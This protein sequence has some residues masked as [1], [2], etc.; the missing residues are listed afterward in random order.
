MTQVLLINMPFASAWTPSMGLSALKASLSEN[1]IPSDVRYFNISY[2]NFVPDINVYDKIAEQWFC[3]EWVFGRELFGKEWAQSKRGDTEGIRW[4]LAANME[5]AKLQ[6]LT[7]DLV[8]FRASAGLFL[9]HCVA[10]VDW[11]NYDIVGFT[12]VFSQQVASLAL[13]K[14]IK[15]LWPDKVI[16][17]GG[18]NCEGEM[19]RG[20]LSLF[21]YVDWVFSGDADISFPL[22]VTSWRK[23]KTFEG[24]EGMAYRQWDKLVY[25]GS[26]CVM[27]M[28]ALPF[29]D[30]DDYFTAI[31]EYASDL[32]GAVSVALEFS[33]GCWW[34]A[35]SQCTFCGL[36][37]QSVEYRCK[38]PG[39]ALKEINHAISR[40]GTSHVRLIDNNI[41]PEYFESLL[42]AL[43]QQENKLESLF[44]ET[45]SNLNRRQML[46]LK[47]AGTKFWQPGIESLDT[48]MLRHMKKGTTT[49][50]TVR[51]LK[52]A[53]EYGLQ[54]EWNFLHSFP[55]EDAESYRRMAALVPLIT[56]FRPPGSITPVILQRFSPLFNDRDA[57]GIKNVKACSAYRFI[58]PFEQED[59]DQVAFLF[60]YQVDENVMPAPGYLDRIK[61]E[62]EKWMEYWKEKEPPLLFF[63]RQKDGK[64]IVYDT[65]PIRRAA[66]WELDVLQMLSIRVCDS[67]IRFPGIA[68]TIKEQMGPDY[69]GDTVLLE[70][71]EQ[72]KDLGFMISEGERY[73]SLANDGEVLA[74]YG[75]SKLVQMLCG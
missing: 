52:W 5:A 44:V 67:D 12:S 22:A 46:T 75:T 72:L 61:R 60:D 34:G 69:P 74:E 18:A 63:E 2:R 62:L 70:C 11:E 21:P 40:H 47:R 31:K 24:I 20:L 26:A 59:L 54:P 16:V 6:R 10:S 33:R 29:P 4:F 17:F 1:N 9:D 73:L 55:G 68:R 38:S 65:R 15:E 35:K 7:D 43:G 30:M 25:Q 8:E 56:H 19:G 36:N 23:G 48:E 42:P 64:G 37:R 27:D 41:A 13:A 45:K 57:W 53:R 32:V 39:R 49:L 3:G 71:L 28:E 50:Q 14:R 51:F 58:Y 66:R